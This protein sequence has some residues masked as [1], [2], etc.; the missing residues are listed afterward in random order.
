[1]AT[2]TI[3]PA[4]LYGPQAKQIQALLLRALSTTP[5]DMEAL[6]EAE[7]YALPTPAQDKAVGTALTLFK[8]L[9]VARQDQGRIATSP[10]WDPQ[11]QFVWRTMVGLMLRD[12]LSTEDYD[13]LT[14][15]WRTN[16]GRI[17]PQDKA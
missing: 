4:K 14:L 3:T 8:T 16:I 11:H 10:V 15:P 6:A 2:T 1:M 9:P 12:L 5:G 13:A 17:H 7:L